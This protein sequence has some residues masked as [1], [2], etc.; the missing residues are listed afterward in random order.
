LVILITIAGFLAA[1]IYVNLIGNKVNYYSS[2]TL[3]S[4]VYGSAEGS[5]EGVAIMNK[6]TDLIGS[7]RVCNRAAQS[8]TDYNIT[9]DELRDMVSSG[10]ISVA[11]ANSNSTAYGYKLTI[12][13]KS[14]S[15]EE[16]IPITNAMASAFAAEL[17]ELISS[18]AIQVMDDA[19]G[20]ASY[21]TMNVSLYLI[22][23]SGAAFVLSCI[24]IFALAFFSPWVRS[25]TQCEQDNDLILGLLPYTKNK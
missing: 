5:S 18:N 3:F 15:Q 1:L 9:S 25:V 23:F 12:S 6:Y 11:G 17:N 20:Y 21:N 4:A 22:L 10:N 2:A 19:T 16:V 13:V 14:D 24:V 7:S 8:L